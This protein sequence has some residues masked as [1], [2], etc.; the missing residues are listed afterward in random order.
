MSYDRKVAFKKIL[1]DLSWSPIGLV[2][3]RQVGK[4]TLGK[5]LQS[6]I[7]KPSIYPAVSASIAATGCL[8]AHCRPF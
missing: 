4:T 6:K 3:S 7:A 1:R 5:S 2:G 8:F